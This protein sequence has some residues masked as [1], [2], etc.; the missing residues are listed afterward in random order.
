MISALATWSLRMVQSGDET[1]W[2]WWGSLKQGVEMLRAGMHG[3]TSGWL[4]F[5]NLSHGMATVSWASHS[6][7]LAWRGSGVGSGPQ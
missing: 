3:V 5:C 2:R 7:R 1:K 6:V 4:P